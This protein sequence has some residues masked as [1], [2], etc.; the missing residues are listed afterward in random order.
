VIILISCR[1]ALFSQ[2]RS[3]EIHLA[4]QSDI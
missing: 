4:C 1:C 3:L 2:T